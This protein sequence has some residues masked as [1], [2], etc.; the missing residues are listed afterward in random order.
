M[1]TKSA[2][3]FLIY[4][5]LFLLLFFSCTKEKIKTIPT[6]TAIIATNITSTTASL[7]GIITA[8]GGATVT[9]SGVC[10]SLKQNP[11]TIDNNSI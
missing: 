10:Y 2:I 4:S 7:G 1:K 3:Y 5:G 8:N 6:V 11:T 9:T